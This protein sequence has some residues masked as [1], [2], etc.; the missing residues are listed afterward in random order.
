MIETEDGVQRM[1]MRELFDDFEGAQ[2]LRRIK[3]WRRQS[4]R[5]AAPKLDARLFGVGLMP[6]ENPNGAIAEMRRCKSERRNFV[7]MLL[8]Q[9]VRAIQGS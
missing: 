5:R 2:G 1:T 8:P 6:I 7:A 9:R 3:K 4:G